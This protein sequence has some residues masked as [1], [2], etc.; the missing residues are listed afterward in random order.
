MRRHLKGGLKIE[1][2][3][4]LRLGGGGLKRGSKF[5]VEWST[6]EFLGGGSQ[7]SNDSASNNSSGVNDEWP[8][9]KQ[10]QLIAKNLVFFERGRFKKKF[11]ALFVACPI[12]TIVPDAKKIFVNWRVVKIRS[13]FILSFF[14][15]DASIKF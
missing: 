12:G 11:S 2:V 3:S 1:L 6:L 10:F 13:N 15:E 5:S 9:Q 7:Y 4:K 14:F 8:L